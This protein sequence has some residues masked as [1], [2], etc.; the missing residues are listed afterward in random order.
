M[1]LGVGKQLLSPLQAVQDL[2]AIARTWSET[3]SLSDQVTDG[4]EGRRVAMEEIIAG[5]CVDDPVV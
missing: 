2:E 4:S 3:E 5:L 1:W